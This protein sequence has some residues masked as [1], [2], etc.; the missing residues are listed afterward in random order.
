MLKKTI[1]INPELF[2]VSNKTKKNK[3]KLVRNINNNI[4][5]KPN[6]IKKELL[7]KIKQHQHR[8]KNITPNSSS[9]NK[10]SNSFNDEFN[11]SINY[12]SSLSKKH[13]D[14]FE[15][16]KKREH[17][18]LNRTVKNYNS[19]ETINN[20]QSPFVNLELPDELK[21]TYVPALIESNTSPTIKINTSNIL[22]NDVPYGCLKGGFKPTFRDWNATKKNYD[23]ILYQNLNPAHS[24]SQKIQISVSP[25]NSTDNNSI[26]N[27]DSFSEQLN[28]R[29]RKLELLRL[30]MKKQEKINSLQSSIQNQKQPNPN[31]VNPNLVNP[32]LVNPNL[33]NPNLV[34]P[35]L[36]NPNLVNPN[37]VHPNPVQPTSVDIS[38]LNTNIPSSAELKEILEESTPKND[39]LFIKKTIRRKYTLGKSKTNNT[40]SI[41][42]KDN[43]TRKNVLNAHKELKRVSM[44]EVKKYLKNRGLIKVGSNAPNDVLRKTYESA[45]L[46]GDVLNKNKDI[47]LHNFLNDIS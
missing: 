47:L 16:E 22:T 21:E 12:L 17:N 41:L 19:Y 44:N 2:N 46:A 37:P 1:K 18:L 5:V 4:I 28:D 11:D 23:S 34:N 3:E 45:M 13:K 38:T 43:N 8:T 26:T 40:V 6:S 35:N 25:P 14:D 31:L 15:R 39:K 33:V 30:K 7:N 42:L 9:E 24:P 36:V 29:E 32:N 20:S 10:K 27:S